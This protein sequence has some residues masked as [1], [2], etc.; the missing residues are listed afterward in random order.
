MAVDAEAEAD[1]AETVHNHFTSQLP[2][3]GR[4]LLGPALP[5]VN[6]MLSPNTA[7]PLL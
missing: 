6:Q 5:F 2:Y 1:L 4:F 7:N 3:T